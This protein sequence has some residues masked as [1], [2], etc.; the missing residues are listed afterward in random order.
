MPGP[1]DDP[2][3]DTGWGGSTA[4]GDGIGDDELVVLRQH[5]GRLAREVDGQRRALDVLGRI[6]GRLAR[7]VVA[8]D[9]VVTRRLTVVDD[10]GAPRLVAETVGDTTELRLELPGTPAGRR[11][12]VVLHATPSPAAGPAGL[13]EEPALTALL[14]LQ[15][16]AEGDAVAE[17]D[18]WPDDDG[19]W[20]AHLHLVDGD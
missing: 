19:R 7:Q 8:R 6:V 10:R 9:E 14:G 4:A 3:D 5:L 16:W 11:S 2:H 15:L 17:L 1:D 20:R 13:P 18:A 12:A